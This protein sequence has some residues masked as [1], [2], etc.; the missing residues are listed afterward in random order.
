MDPSA[1]FD[2]LATDGRVQPVLDRVD[3]PR[4]ILG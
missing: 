3:K 2:A 4:L 1:L